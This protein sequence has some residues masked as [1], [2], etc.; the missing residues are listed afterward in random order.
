MVNHQH[1]IQASGRITDWVKITD[2]EAGLSSGFE[3]SRRSGDNVRVSVVVWYVE[4]TNSF[5]LLGFTKVVGSYA[6]VCQAF[7]CH[8]LGHEI[9]FTRSWKTSE[10]RQRV[11]SD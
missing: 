7:T 10:Q 3:H 8:V 11:S 5:A 6:D 4:V 1:S 9:N 2:V